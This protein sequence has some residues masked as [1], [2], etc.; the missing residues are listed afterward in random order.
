[1]NK[2]KVKVLSDIPGYAAGVVLN[3]DADE[4]GTPYSQFWRR[5]L[6]DAKTD[7]CL[8]IQKEPTK[9]KPSKSKTPE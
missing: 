3:L 5:R 4:N 9:L 6:R 1:M 7:N 8:E 2:I